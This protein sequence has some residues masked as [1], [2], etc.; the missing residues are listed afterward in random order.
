MN[1][2]NYDFT[3]DTAVLF[4]FIEKLDLKVSIEKCHVRKHF[5]GK[6]SAFGKHVIFVSLQH[7]TSFSVGKFIG[8][9]K[10]G[11][12]RCMVI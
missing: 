7:G 3:S 6:F 4:A 11:M 2:Q 12:T 8:G 5:K 1:W 10:W 9:N